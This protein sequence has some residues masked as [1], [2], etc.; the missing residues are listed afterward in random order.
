MN[1]DSYQ[2]GDTSPLFTGEIFEKIEKPTNDW[3]EQ[4]PSQCNILRPYQAD[5]LKRLM[6]SLRTHRRVLGQAPT[7]AGKSMLIAALVAAARMGDL[8]VLIL[9]TRTRLVKQLH[10]RLNDFQLPHGIM[11][12]SLPGLASWSKPIQIASV[13][14]LYR[15]CLADKRH[16]T[17]LADLVVFDEAHLALGASRR[18]VLDAYPLAYHVGFTATPAKTSGV[19]LDAQFDHME[20]GPSA[21]ELIA[22]KALVPIRIFAKP[23]VS[24]AELQAVGK[25]SKTGDYVTGEISKIMLRPKLVGN[26]VENWLRI[27]NGKR[28]IVFACDKKHGAELQQEFSRVGV[29]CE[30]LTDG[31]AEEVRE[32]VIARLDAGITHVLVNCFL[33]SYGIDI[34]S[35]ECIV[36]ARPTRSV[37]LMLQAIGRGMRP[38]PD[39]SSMI[40]IDHGRVI[41]NLGLP[42]YEREWSLK[43]GNVNKQAEERY[44]S[45]KVTVEK[46]RTCPDCSRMWVLSEEG[47][48]CPE[49]GYQPIIRAAGVRVTDAEL[50]EIGAQ[51]PSVDVLQPFFREACDWYATRWPDRWQQKEKSG[52]WWAW[53]QTREK[54]KRPD[55][56]RM[57]SLFWNVAPLKASAETSGWL[58]AKIKEFKRKMARR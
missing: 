11:A 45:R 36:L 43:G 33:L 39:K 15:R 2:Q 4:W 8:R 23:V 29:S 48:R 26:V 6:A 55:D 53:M 54:F 17:P 13:D 57:P 18:A 41:D 16:P 38:A 10:E 31:D 21:A 51:L 44:S 14:T 37:V 49:C 7:G 30:Q 28:T 50:G 1:T 35:V 12:A 40:L 22:L 52:R 3:L 5:L 32:E 47:S 58:T 27:A 20:L 19:G 46:P 42:T 25:D 9:A 34:P 24:K 56:E